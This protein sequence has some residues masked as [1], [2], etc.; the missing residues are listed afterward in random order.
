MRKV[1]RSGA[2]ALIGLAAAGRLGAWP[3]AAARF[4][5]GSTR[6]AQPPAGLPADSRRHVPGM[7]HVPIIGKADVARRA[8]VAARRRQGEARHATAVSSSNWAGYADTNDT[9]SS[10]SS[11]W[12]EPAVNCARTVVAD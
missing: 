11:S 6:I 3:P 1:L 4:G 8:G 7:Y 2:L 5:G 10:V 9:Y 12:T